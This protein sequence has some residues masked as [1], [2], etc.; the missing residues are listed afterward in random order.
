MEGGPR[1]TPYQQQNPSSC[2][3]WHLFVYEQRCLGSGGRQQRDHALASPAF[4]LLPHHSQRVPCAKLSPQRL[5]SAS[6]GSSD[7]GTV[8]DSLDAL[9]H[10]GASVDSMM[11]LCWVDLED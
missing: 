4:S 10:F 9:R 6:N 8:S 5:G 3:N 2:T 11:A 1:C 7:L